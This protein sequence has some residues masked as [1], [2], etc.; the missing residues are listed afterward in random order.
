MST[1]TP[2]TA[3]TYDHYATTTLIDVFERGPE[4]LRKVITGL[5]DAEL[6]L[7]VIPGKWS[8]FEIVIH[9][10]EGEII[11]A[12]RFRQALARHPDAFPYYQEAVW[13][14][15]MQYQQQSLQFLR[16]NVA[17]FGMLRATTAD[18]LKRCTEEDWQKAG[19]HP[20]R[21]RMTMRQLLELY[22]DHSERHISQILER[23]EC[24]GKDRPVKI[25]LEDRL[26]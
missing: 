20:M 22:A 13:A 7:Q 2:S 1:E 23:R 25:L 16:D 19:T 24:M 17:L 15:V 26:Y 5:S 9:L 4:R 14:Q 11:G 21:G 12:C 10:A 18:L 6:K 3:A 8:I